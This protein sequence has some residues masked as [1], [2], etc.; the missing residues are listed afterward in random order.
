MAKKVYTE[1]GMVKE[2]YRYPIKS[3]A[4]ETLQESKIG[5]HGLDGDRRFG[6]VKLDSQRGF[7]WLTARDV[8]QLSLYCPYF[9]DPKDIRHSQL[10][11]KTPSGSDLELH[12]NQLLHE[13]SYLSHHD[14]HLLQNWSGIFDA[15][16]ISILSTASIMAVGDATNQHLETGRFRPNILVEAYSD[17]PF[18]E[19]QWVKELIVFGD[20]AD[21]T[22]IR[23]NRKIQRC[24]V[25][26]VDLKT[27]IQT[28]SVLKEVV[29]NRKNLLGVYAT[30]EWPGTIKVG[31]V[32][33][34]L[35]P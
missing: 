5:W 15:M 17:K 7:P 11:V 12:D 18:P 16:D 29:Q 27:S 19:D 30:T 25:I 13:I 9:V 33:R 20:R 2:I 31:D 26:N 14:I 24:M 8:P 23:I 21:S 28:P 1:V 22:R 10:R 34:L 6:F 3:F 35:Q 32:I 4:G